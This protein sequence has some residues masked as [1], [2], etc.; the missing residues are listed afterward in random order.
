MWYEGREGIL[1]RV[2]LVYVW[3]VPWLA[4]SIYYQNVAMQ[5]C[6]SALE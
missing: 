6:C 1:F 5:K 4:V 3:E 2:L